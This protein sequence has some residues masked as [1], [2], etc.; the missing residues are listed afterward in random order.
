MKKFSIT[1]ID[2]SRVLIIVSS[3]AIFILFSMFA[4]IKSDYLNLFTFSITLVLAILSF[5]YFKKYFTYSLTLGL[6][7]NSFLTLKNDIEEDI[8]Y[9]E[10]R[11]YKIEELDGIRLEVRLRNNKKITIITSNNFGSTPE[12]LKDFCNHFEEQIKIHQNQISLPIEKKKSFF[13]TRLALYLLITIS[14]IGLGCILY[15]VFTN[16]KMNLGTFLVIVIPIIS[17]LPALLK[18]KSSPPPR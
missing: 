12:I 16:K 2:Q 6:Q 8:P 10:I 5:F 9:K 1:A 18:V 14:I 17:L 7:E 11:S 13:E 4:L 3:I 15:A